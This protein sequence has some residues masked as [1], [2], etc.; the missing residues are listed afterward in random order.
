M[1]QQNLNYISSQQYCLEY[2]KRYILLK[3]I[4]RE[5]YRQILA[6]Y[7]YT[8]NQYQSFFRKVENQDIS[9]NENEILERGLLGKSDDT[10]GGTLTAEQAMSQGTLLASGDNSAV[11]DALWNAERK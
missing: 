11:G 4:I 1:N 5:I 6:D 3:L 8:L 9:Y 7:C 2:F 10:S